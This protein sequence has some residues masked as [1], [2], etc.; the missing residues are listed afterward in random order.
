MSTLKTLAAASA[1]SLMLL[2]KTAHAQASYVVVP[3]VQTPMSREEIAVALKQGHVRVF[4]SEPSENRLA[5]SWSQVA[6]ENG[7]GTYVWNHNLGNT[8][9]WAAGQSAYYNP[10]DHNYY[11]SF[12]TFSDGAAA[13]WATIKRCTAALADF[14]KGDSTKASHD[15]K[16]CHYYEAPEA[17]YAKMLKDLFDY[18]KRTVL[19]AVY[20]AERLRQQIQQLV[21]NSTANPS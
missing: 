18:S 16:V 21:G 9:P 6:L 1:L 10:G 20:N 19:P 8:T 3:M 15:L 4:G 13:Y 2:S 5:M 11:K 7:H 12:A 14:D 17:P